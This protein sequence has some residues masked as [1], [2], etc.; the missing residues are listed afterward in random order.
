MLK[1]WGED[2]SPLREDTGILGIPELC[3]T[4]TCPLIG[5]EKEAPE[6][7]HGHTSTDWYPLL[8]QKVPL[9]PGLWDTAL[10]RTVLWGPQRC[11]Q[12]DK[13][14]KEAPH[15]DTRQKADVHAAFPG[16][17]GRCTQQAPVARTTLLSLS[18]S[19]HFSLHSF[20]KAS[21]LCPAHHPIQQDRQIINQTQQCRAPHAR[22]EGHEH[23]KEDIKI[24]C[25]GGSRV[26]ITQA[27]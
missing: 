16:T 14:P 20:K 22:S 13:A 5:R 6:V 11:C 19:F 2:S 18:P 17:E 26:Q 9:T 21:A 1:Q 12:R 4:P 24:K 27:S 15:R 7:H 3:P 25:E 23:L 10:P 8:T